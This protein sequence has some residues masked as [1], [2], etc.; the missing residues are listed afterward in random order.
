ML[1]V[2]ISMMT[3]IINDII[4]IHAHLFDR[5]IINQVSITIKD[6]QL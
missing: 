5:K 6:Q 2:A 1:K 4:T 3:A